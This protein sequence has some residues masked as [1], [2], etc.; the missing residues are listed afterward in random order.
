MLFDVSLPKPGV[1]KLLISASVEG[2]PFTRVLTYYLNAL[3][4]YV[5]PQPVNVPPAFLAEGVQPLNQRYQVIQAKEGTITCIKWRVPAG[6][7]VKATLKENTQRLDPS[8]YIVI[9][10]ESD[11]VVAIDV[12]LPAPAKK[13]RTVVQPA[14]VL[15]LF[16]RP[17]EEVGFRYLTNYII[18]V[19][20]PDPRDARGR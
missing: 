16:L 10:R 19:V 3:S 13:Q 12:M 14:Y 20:S 11:E 6:V 18:Q 7:H 4:D 15:S 1:Y 17:E 5:A 8:S 9:R 2:S